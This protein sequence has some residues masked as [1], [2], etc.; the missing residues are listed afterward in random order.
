MINNKNIVHDK[1]L[2]EILKKEC[3]NIA[4]DIRT[5]QLLKKNSI[6]TYTFDYNPT[7]MDLCNKK[8]FTY[9]GSRVDFKL[10]DKNKIQSTNRDDYSIVTNTK[11]LDLENIY[12]IAED[13]AKTS[14]FYKDQYSKEYAFSIYKEWIKNSLMHAYA[15]DFFVLKKAETSIAIVTLKRE[16][17]GVRID[18]IGVSDEYQKKGMGT[19][20]INLI[21]DKYKDDDIF[22]GAQAEHI[23]ALNFYY[24]NG[25]VAEAYK[26][27]YRKYT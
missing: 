22:V 25:F 26:V 6:Y 23:G 3:F 14:R 19:I 10:R 4:G 7:V 17:K 18:L 12:T 5:I 11:S 21:K 9:W 24:K 15:D 2:S 8:G 1:F 20:L 16:E 13:I 27:I